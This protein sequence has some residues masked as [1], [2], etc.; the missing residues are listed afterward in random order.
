MSR[1]SSALFAVALGWI[2]AAGPIASAQGIFLAETNLRDA[3]FSNEMSMKMTGSVNVV[4]NGQSVAIPRSAEATN[5]Y[6]ER[7]LDIKEGS[8]ERTARFYNRLEATIT[9]AKDVAKIVLKSNHTLLVAHRTKERLLVYHPTD[10]LTRE[11]ID[12]TS[13]FDSMA[14]PGLLPRTKCKVDATWTVPHEIVQ[15]APPISTP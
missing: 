8:G 11:E 12:V 5:V 15:A 2:A 9:D 13:H 4:Q 6:F 1:L 10:V 14:V 7:F 3:S